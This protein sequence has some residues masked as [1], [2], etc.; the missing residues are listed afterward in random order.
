VCDWIEANVYDSST[1]SLAGWDYSHARLLR[2]E[3]YQRRILSA[4]LTP[5]ESGRFPYRTVVWSQIKKSGK[6]Q[7]AGAVGAWWASEIE[8]PNLVLCLANDEEQ[9]AG[10]I[11]SAMAPTVYKLTGDFPVG[12]TAKPEIRLPNGTVIKALPNNYAGEAGANYG[13]TLWSE[14]WAYT[15]ERSRR[16]FDE[17][18][19][20]PTRRNS[21]R[22]VETYAG[23][24]D[25]SDLLLEIFLKVFRDTSESSLTPRARRVTGL[26]DLPCYE[27]PDEGLFVFWDHERRMTWQQGE[28]GDRYYREMAASLR[29]SAYI[30]LCENRWQK[31]AGD[32]IPDD[33][34]RRSLSLSGPTL[35]QMILAADASQRH[36]TTSLVGMRR[37]GDRYRTC[38]VKVWNPHGRDIDLDETLTAEILALSEQGLIDE[39]WYDPY[40]LH[41][42]MLNLRKHGIEAKEFPQGEERVRADTFLWKLYRDGAIDN[43][44][45]PDLADH[46]RAAK[47]KEQENERLR[48][49]KGTASNAGK[50]DAVVAQSMA[51]YKASLREDYG[52]PDVIDANA[53]IFGGRIEYADEPP[54][55]ARHAATREH[56]KWSMRNFCQQCYEAF[57]ATE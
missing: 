22:W 33:W 55:A 48:I 18:M 7:I 12:K 50:V 42:I 2:L 26:E 34:Y 29:P 3:E 54:T 41:Q 53:F 56:R 17:L 8:A 13:L 21:V 11:F 10:R 20:V 35:N 24:E 4:V 43:Y 57:R 1:V 5:D 25:E 14:L 52:P 45:D 47:A 16:L 51:A 38:Y 49:V 46:I 36:D 9:S 27:V 15:S 32:F 40:Q 44:P 39:L 31:S 28:A 19:P 30:R 37:E 6:T 23:F